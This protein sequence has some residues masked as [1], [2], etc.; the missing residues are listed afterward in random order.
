MNPESRN[1][2]LVPETLNKVT[3][4]TA[5]VVRKNMPSIRPTNK[6]QNNTSS[7]IKKRPGP[8]SA[9]RVQR[10][11]QNNSPICRLKMR[12]GPA[13]AKRVHETAQNNTPIC[14]LKMRPGPASA[15]RVHKTAPT[16]PERLEK[17]STGLCEKRSERAINSFLKCL[18]S[19]RVQVS[20]GADLLPS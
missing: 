17:T 15:K 16:S 19:E 7:S 5:K 4:V 11:A 2:N 12:P 9:K 1:I 14:R 20:V 18:V 3:Y 6:I 13:S 10:T 8:A